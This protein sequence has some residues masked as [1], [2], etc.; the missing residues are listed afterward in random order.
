MHDLLFTE[1][2]KLEDSDL[3]TA[4]RT[5]GVDTSVFGSCLVGSAATRVKE[6]VASAQALQLSGTPAFL[7]GILQSDG[8]IKVH[9]SVAGAA[10]PEEFSKIIE[11]LLRA[12]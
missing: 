9:Q 4:A 7:V 12:K 8:K 2:G 11:P 10:P 1:P 6:D 3:Q 5:I